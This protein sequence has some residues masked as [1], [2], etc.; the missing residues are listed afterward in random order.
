MKRFLVSV[1]AV[2]FGCLAGISLYSIADETDQTSFPKLTEQEI[3]T[4]KQNAASQ[5]EK[6]TTPSAKAEDKKS[7]QSDPQG[8]KKLETATF[9][10]GCFWCT[11]AVFQ[12]LKGVESVQSGYSGGKVANPTYKEVCT[13]RTGHAE[14]V[15]IQFDPQ[16]IS[17]SKLL[18]VFWRTHD[19]TTLNR[20][21]AD[22]GTQYRS[23]V[24]YHSNE[25]KELAAAYKQR[26]DE[27]KVF[28][29]PIVTEITEASVFYPAE[30]YHQNYFN[31][32]GREP[33]CRAVI[34]PKVEK[35]KKVFEADLKE[36]QTE[37]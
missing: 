37:K 24:F 28:D 20:Q 31:L 8:E 23:A 36:D 11:E 18:E 34:I 10:N 7:D 1:A 6:S 26:L 35:F 19:P 12:R 33:Y 5:K 21:G 16:V 22:A 3:N 4:A 27:A 14:V 29:D 15:Q 9:G 32:N 2:L 25:Q 13:G 30:D 17:Y